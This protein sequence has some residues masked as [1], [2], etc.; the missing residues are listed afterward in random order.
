M[1]SLP[2]LA[3]R[4]LRRRAGRTALTTLGVGIGAAAYLL[5]V[6]SG[7][8][9]EREFERTFS[10][11]GGD[12]TVQRAGAALPESSRLTAAEVARI[13]ALPG[14]S[15]TSPVAVGTTRVSAS[16]HFLVIGV[17][18]EDFAF[19]PVRVL[20]GRRLHAGAGE[21]MAGRHAARALDL[22]PGDEVEITGRRRFAVVGVFE[23]GRGILDNAAVIDLAAAQQAFDLGD[24][25][26]LLFVDLADTVAPDQAC[27]D[28]NRALPRVWAAPS[29]AYIASF[30]QLGAV[31]RFARFLAVVALLVATLGVANTMNMNVA[32]RERELGILRAVGWRR[33]RIA[34][35]VALE[36]TLLAGAGALGGLA[37]ALVALA[38]LPAGGV[39]WIA[40]AGIGWETVVE[41]VLLTVGAGLAGTL[42][43]L[44][45]ALAVQPVRALRGER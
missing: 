24:Q 44:L 40:P 41:G 22:A 19:H 33:R 39:A 4:G 2:A 12:V 16:S 17:D 18:P 3:G 38:L 11:V 5:L 35:L 32:E 30:Q 36:G 7:R 34:A 28:I 25:V 45:R 29:D 31:R 15:R 42:P 27:A 23:T 43:A 26:N 14:V 1:L 21:M 9:L 6:A 37:A 20:A 10:A 8:G 13:A